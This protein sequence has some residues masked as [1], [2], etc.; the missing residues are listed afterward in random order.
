MKNLESFCRY[1]GPTFI[2]GR[3]LAL[4]PLLPWSTTVSEWTWQVTWSF[5]VFVLLIDVI[6][7][8]SFNSLMWNKMEFT[9]LLTM[10]GNESIATRLRFFKCDF[11]NAFL[12]S[13]K[14]H[15]TIPINLQYPFTH[16][17]SINPWVSTNVLVLLWL[18]S[19]YRPI[20]VDINRYN[21]QSVCVRQ[22]L[23]VTCCIFA[24]SFTIN[25]VR[26]VS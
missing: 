19:I 25:V 6:L 5:T 9:F 14:F 22:S 12:S 11:C 10:W 1:S 24:I 16:L 4:L 13:K 8:A 26:W 23:F 2:E 21:N 3:G 15:L 18:D 17:H 7:F 20:S